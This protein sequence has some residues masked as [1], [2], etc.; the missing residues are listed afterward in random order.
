MKSL[1][2]IL[3][4]ISYLSSE[5][6]DDV[7]LKGICIDSR[8]VKKGDLFIAI[9]GENRD[10][11]DF[12]EEALDLGAVALIVNK[13]VVV[14]RNVAKV[15]VSDTQKALAEI[16]ALFY[17]LPSE[18]LSVVGITGT[19]GKTTISYL[20][21]S[22]L[23][24]SGRPAALMGTIEYKIGKKS[25]PAVNTTPQVNIVERLLDEAVHQGDKYAIMEVSSHALAQG[26]VDK[27]RFSHAIFTNLTQEHLDYH[28]TM[29]D[30]FACKSRLFV[31]LS[32]NT[33]AIINS[34]DSYGKELIGKTKAQVL[35]YGLEASADLRA[36]NVR[37]DSQ[38]I[39]CSIECAEG[40]FEIESPLIGMHNVYNIL[41]AVGFCL[42]EGLDI[43]AIQSG[44]KAFRGVR[45]RLECIECGQ[46]F[47]IFVDY[48]HTENALTVVLQSLRNIK[49]EDGKIIV[50]FGC[51]G[52]RD[53]SK[54]PK[55]G[56]VAVE[57]AD[58]AIVTSDNPRSEKPEFIAQDIVSCISNRKNNYLVELDRYKAIQKAIEHA[59]PGDIVLIAGKGHESS[60]V[61]A[62]ETIS[63]SDQKAIRE[64]LKCSA[65]KK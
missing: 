48:A 7:S 12:I 63:F 22:L 15:I 38:G 55:M 49:K 41:A 17:D 16:S 30:Y 14:S 34:D 10:G 24:Y 42:L 35:S 4:K 64:I 1:K 5:N 25:Y 21:E 45:G 26:R 52:D 13:E 27:V 43:P 29:A 11:H 60:Q 44:L 8:A 18:K 32:E 37:L 20:I 3:E 46:P 36:C 9:E 50:V 40:N 57:L 47:S 53:K 62:K 2:K 61:F 54:R 31:E 65:L 28:K 51:G 59:K 6:A 23:A 58:F 39:T 33:R 56:E 19:N